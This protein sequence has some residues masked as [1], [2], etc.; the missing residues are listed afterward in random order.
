MAAVWLNAVLKNGPKFHFSRRVDL[1][2]R[3]LELGVK[4]IWFNC[5]GYGFVKTVFA[6]LVNFFVW[7]NDF[8][9]VNAHRN[10]EQAFFSVFLDHQTFRQY[11]SGK[12]PRKVK[13]DL[14]RKFVSD[15]DFVNDAFCCVCF[16]VFKNG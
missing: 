10:I 7:Q 3:G 12:T 5:N 15:A 1:S 4:L 9:R 6:A 16:F 2:F 11:N 14:V 13:S 8:V